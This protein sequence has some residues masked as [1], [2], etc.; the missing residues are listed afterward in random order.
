MHEDRKF[1]PG[2][3]IRDPIDEDSYK[4]EIIRHVVTGE[5]V[6]G[7]WFDGSTQKEITSNC[8]LVRGYRSGLLFTLGYHV[9]QFFELI[10]LVEANDRINK[11]YR[12]VCPHCRAP[13]YIGLNNIDC[14]R[15]C[16]KQEE[17]KNC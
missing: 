6:P 12:G 4:F 17:N 8:Y 16:Q 11:D 10:E 1:K 3:I 9:E 14:S 5:L 7:T 13:A 15:N 2:D